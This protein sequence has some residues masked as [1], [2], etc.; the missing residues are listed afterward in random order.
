[1]SSFNTFIS[2]LLVISGALTAQAEVLFEPSVGYRTESL[3]LTNKNTNAETKVTMATPVYGLK[4]GYR[5]PLGVDVNLAGDYSAGKAKYTV[6]EEQNSFTHTTL[7]AQ[8]GISAM[9][10]MK[11]YLG[12]GFS[13][14]LK[15]D[16]GP[17]NS[18]MKLKG[19]AYQAGL[20]FRI[21][22]WFSVGAQYSLNQFNSIEGTNYA[23]GSS[24]DLYYSKVDSQDLSLTLSLIF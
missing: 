8:L 1:M 24:P 10:L 17:L 7:A 19:N 16:A 14:E 9:G 20:Q 2:F 22:Q 3:K 23:A 18:D 4:L 21:S 13:N 11:I 15:I 12:Y 5:S 6:L